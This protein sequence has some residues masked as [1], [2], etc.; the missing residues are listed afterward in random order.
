[1]K[2]CKHIKK[3]LAMAGVM[4]LLF[5]SVS[6]AATISDQADFSG[7]NSLLE[8]TLDQ[9][10]DSQGTLNSIYVELYVESL[11][12]YLIIDN[13]AASSL[14]G[15]AEFGASATYLTSSVTMK[16]GTGTDIFSITSPFEAIDTWSGTLQADDGDGATFSSVGTDA[17]TLN[18]TNPNDSG[19]DYIGE[20]YFSDFIGEDT[21]T[22]TLFETA[23]HSENNFNPAPQ[24]QQDPPTITGYFKVTYDYTSSTVPEPASV[25]L[26]GAGLIGLAGVSRKRLGLGKKA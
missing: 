6:M 7:V 18:G 2:K 11:G 5:S 4:V 24:S 13:D 17:Y 20:S 12:G 23:T 21:F 1:M 8:L 19:G 26:F 10:D 25:L 14:S 3:M 22:V 9:F 15:N 16:D